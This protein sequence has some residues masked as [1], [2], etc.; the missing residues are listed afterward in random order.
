MVLL[1]LRV[2]HIT[3]LYGSLARNPIP[4]NSLE[5]RWLRKK[6]RFLFVT[7]NT[8][9]QGY[10]SDSRTLRRYFNEALMTS[11]VSILEGDVIVFSKTEDQHLND[12]KKMFKTL[13]EANLKVQ[14]DK[15]KFLHKEVEF[16]GLSFLQKDKSNQS[17][18]NSWL[19]RT[20]KEL[21][22]DFRLIQLLS[23]ICEGLCKI[24]Q[25]PDITPKRWRRYDFKVKIFYCVNK[26]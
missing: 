24:S 10:L 14:L 18:S 8:G 9:L 2:P 21:K 4:L 6:W 12:I 17:G 13:G 11:F 26:L 22:E 25:A 19:P 15:C 23:K 3:S 7:V 20:K 5:T 16:L 1:H